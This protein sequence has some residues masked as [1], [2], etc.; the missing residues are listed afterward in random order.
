MN[1]I[2]MAAGTASRFV[3]LSEEIPKGLLEVRGEVLIERQIKQLQEAGIADITIVLGYKAELFQ[4]LAD[5]YGVCLIYNEDYNRFNNT[6][7]MI[8]VVERLG[9]TYICCSDHYFTENVFAEK[10]IDSY[11]AALYA[12]GQ[13]NEYCL[14][15]DEVNWITDV[16][17]G[18]ADAW[19]MAG[20]VFFNSQFSTKFRDIFVKEY[21]KEATRQGY[22]EDVYLKHLDELPMKAR[23]Y[24]PGIINEFDSIDELRLFDTSYIG[25]TRSS[26]V[27]Q[28]CSMLSCKEENLHTFQRI[29]HSGDYLLFSFKK[30]NALYIFDGSDVSIKPNSL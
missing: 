8:R 7:S 9:E 3:P 21:Q 2:I 20:H 14:E 24:Q 16:T 19:Y 5:K 11:Y 4:Y 22:W 26:V 29:K 6:S 12:Q 17:V 27:K 28:I 10:S 1:A 23:K 15:L 18:G 25:D 13:T 30:G